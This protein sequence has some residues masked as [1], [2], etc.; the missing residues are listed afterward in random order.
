M[1]SQS[2]NKVLYIT[3]SETIQLVTDLVVENYG[4][5]RKHE[6]AFELIVLQIAYVAYKFPNQWIRINEA[7]CSVK[8]V[9]KVKEVFR[10]FGDYENRT[11]VARSCVEADAWEIM[12]QHPNSQQRSMSGYTRNV[13]LGNFIP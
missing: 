8:A 4:S 5:P 3:G 2:E 12:V 13:V 11:V 6:N 1:T 7:Q 9:Q 10:L